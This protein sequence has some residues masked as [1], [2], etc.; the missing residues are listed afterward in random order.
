[1]LRAQRGRLNMVEVQEYF[2]LFDRT[3]MLHELLA[4][5]A[6]TKHESVRE[7]LVGGYVLDVVQAG[8]GDLSDW[9]ELME[10]VEALCPVWPV[11]PLGMH[12]EY[13]L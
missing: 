1:M 4:E 9:V 11:A 10:A 12:D 5:S 13:R 8:T 2:A 6:T 7:P 3:E